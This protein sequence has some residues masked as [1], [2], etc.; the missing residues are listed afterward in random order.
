MY[1]ASFKESVVHTGSVF[2]TESRWS[3]WD[4]DPSFLIVWLLP[5]SHA[6]PWIKSLKENPQSLPTSDFS[7]S[8]IIHQPRG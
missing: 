3:I 7:G 4:S 5:S 2:L 8:Y 6:T 1:Q